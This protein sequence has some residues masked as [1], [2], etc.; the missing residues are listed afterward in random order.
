[1]AK[2]LVELVLSLAVNFAWLE[3]FGHYRRCVN[4]RDN[5]KARPP[6]SYPPHVRDDT[7]RAWATMK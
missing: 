6:V 1:M 7:L 5:P 2:L 3:L 4:L